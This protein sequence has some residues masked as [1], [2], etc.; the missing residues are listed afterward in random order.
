MIRRKAAI[1]EL[2]FAPGRNR[3]FINQ[4][5]MRIQVADRLIGQGGERRRKLLVGARAYKRR[6]EVLPLRQPLCLDCCVWTQGEGMI[7]QPTGD[8][9]SERRLPGAG[10]Q[11]QVGSAPTLGARFFRRLPAPALDSGGMGGGTR[12]SRRLR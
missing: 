5:V 8:F 11:N 3:L 4:R 9:Q 12:L 6:L 10:W 2:A 1:S 7:A